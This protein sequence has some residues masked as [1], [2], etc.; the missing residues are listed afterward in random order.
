M[1]TWRISDRRSF[2]R[3][4]AT[5]VRVRSGPLTVTGE[6]ASISTPPRIGYAIGRTVGPAVVRN[7]IRRRLRA[8]AA[9][10]GLPPGTF[11]VSVAPR[12]AGA[13]FDELRHHLAGA[14]AR[15]SGSR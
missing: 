4:R 1:P 6:L 15:L 2:A 7:R 12:A 10:I 11:V 13:S 8:A 5:G 14:V 9:E 3:L